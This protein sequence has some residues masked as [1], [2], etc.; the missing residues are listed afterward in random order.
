[1]ELSEPRPR[2]EIT[3][4]CF[5]HTSSLVAQCPLSR[6]SP[7]PRYPSIT[8]HSLHRQHSVFVPRYLLSIPFGLSV[9][10]LDDRSIDV[11]FGVAV[12]TT[13]FSIYLAVGLERLHSGNWTYVNMR[14]P[15]A[16]LCLMYSR[17][18]AKAGAR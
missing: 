8:A 18:T 12:S 14:G 9:L 7:T 6:I 16:H 5:Q 11:Y 3:V 2:D 4:G 15:S 1:M 13:D 17:R 10:N